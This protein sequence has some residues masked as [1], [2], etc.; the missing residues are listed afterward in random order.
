[1]PCTR[2]AIKGC[3]GQGVLQGV[4]RCPARSLRGERLHRKSCPV[5]SRADRNFLFQGVVVSE[6]VGARTYVH[7]HGHF[8]SHRADDK[9]VVVIENSMVMSNNS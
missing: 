5:T 3:A 7:V 8:Q 6:S 4:L 2:F 9:H 1:M